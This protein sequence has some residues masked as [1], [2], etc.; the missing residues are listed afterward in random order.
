M[1]NFIWRKNHE[2]SRRVSC[3]DV[4]LHRILF[5]N[6]PILSLDRCSPIPIYQVKNTKINR[7]TVCCL[8][9]KIT[10][11]IG[12]IACTTAPVTVIV[13]SVVR[14]VLSLVYVDTRNGVRELDRTLQTPEFRIFGLLGGKM[15]NVAPGLFSVCQVCEFTF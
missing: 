1:I 2:P 15:E 10:T 3:I 6:R 4:S 5:F 14:I 11:S 13:S 9:G 8:L 12:F 7:S